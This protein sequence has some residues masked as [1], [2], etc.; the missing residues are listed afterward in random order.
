MSFPPPPK[1]S[2][3]TLL[4]RPKNATSLVL[5]TSAAA[6]ALEE[7]H[8]PVTAGQ[9]RHPAVRQRADDVVETADDREGP[10]PRRQLRLPLATTGKL[11]KTKGK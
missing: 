11:E 1:M 8:R 2:S 7:H 5:N 9:L 6:S 10:W 4:G 3:V